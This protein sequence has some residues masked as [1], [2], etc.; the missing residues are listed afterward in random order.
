MF[1]VYRPKSK[2]QL[3]PSVTAAAS[4]T[5]PPRLQLSVLFV[6]LAKSP[7]GTFGKGRGL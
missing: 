7:K 5:V 2:K 6:H 4:D 3:L 1:D